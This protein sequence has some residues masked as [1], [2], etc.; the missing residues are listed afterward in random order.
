MREI[1]SQRIRLKSKD[2]PPPP[3]NVPT[4]AAPKT[5]ELKDFS[6][7]KN[8]GQKGRN[9]PESE[10]PSASKKKKFAASQIYQCPLKAK[11][12]TLWYRTP[13]LDPDDRWAPTEC[14]SFKSVIRN[15]KKQDKKLC[16]GYVWTV[17]PGD[18]YVPNKVT[19]VP[20]EQKCAFDGG[21]LVRSSKPDLMKRLQ[22]DEKGSVLLFLGGVRVNSGLIPIKY[23]HCGDTP[24]GKKCAQSHVY[25]MCV[26]LNN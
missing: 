21:T 6:A 15:A 25:T 7:L 5:K 1:R 20:I 17:L 14:S 4:K 2:C 8:P 24:T 22:G 9:E 23:K 11:I 12:H 10:P 16:E 13:R 19:S 3:A 26:C 18:D